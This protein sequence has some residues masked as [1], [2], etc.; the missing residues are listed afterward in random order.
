M[1]VCTEVLGH[2]LNSDNAGQRSLSSLS[3]VLSNVE[4]GERGREWRGEGRGGKKR[5]W[6]EGAPCIRM[7]VH[8][9]TNEDKGIM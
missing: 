3:S 1:C 8:S 5:G 9:L 6:E 4:R 2:S 7:C